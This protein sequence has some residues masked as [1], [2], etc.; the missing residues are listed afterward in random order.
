AASRQGRSLADAVR[1]HLDTMRS[2]PSAQRRT[3]LSGNLR[4][5]IASINR[6]IRRAPAAPDAHTEADYGP[7]G[8]AMERAIGS[9]RPKAFSGFVTVFRAMD[10]SQTGT[11]GRTLGW[12][13]LAAGGIRVIDI[14]GDHGTILKGDG[15]RALAANLRQCI[16]A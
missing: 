16:D 13:R 4:R 15:V 10:R 8:L 1:L 11:Y 9:Y 12:K 14:P 3:Y 6:R 5:F 2:M 7:V